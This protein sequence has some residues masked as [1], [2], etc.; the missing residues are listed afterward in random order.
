MTIELGG[1]ALP[2]LT[3]FRVVL[4]IDAGAALFA[5]LIAAFLP[6]SARSGDRQLARRPI[7]RTFARTGRRL[8]R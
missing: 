6:G 4:G 8:R 3:G 5:L 2:S 7:A 1:A